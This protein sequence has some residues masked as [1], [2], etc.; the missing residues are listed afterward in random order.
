M[1]DI[2]MYS[3]VVV[4]DYLAQMVHSVKS[5]IKSDQIG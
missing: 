4:I 3:V 1:A 5:A 2:L